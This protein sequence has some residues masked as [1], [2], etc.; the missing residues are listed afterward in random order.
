MSSTFLGNENIALSDGTIR[1]PP[2][3]LQPPA[4]GNS[5]QASESAAQGDDEGAPSLTTEEHDHLLQEIAAGPQSV[6][7]GPLKLEEF[8]YD[9]SEAKELDSF[10]SWS[11]GR[12]RQAKVRDELLPKQDDLM[13]LIIYHLKRRPFHIPSELDERGNGRM[14]RTERRLLR[15][16]WD[17]V[18]TFC[19]HAQVFYLDDKPVACS[20]IKELYDAVMSTLVALEKRLGP[21]FS[22]DHIPIPRMPRFGFSTLR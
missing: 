8:V 18:D 7:G 13:D 5:S 22:R 17:L 3:H 4:S 16:Y 2:P 12:A 1:D 19:S 14:T 20:P 15:S 6:F 9:A 21:T 10:W 11:E